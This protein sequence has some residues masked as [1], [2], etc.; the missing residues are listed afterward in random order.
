MKKSVIKNLILSYLNENEEKKVNVQFFNT[1]HVPQGF[2]DYAEKQSCKIDIEGDERIFRETFWELFSQNLVTVG[3]EKQGC[4]LPWVSITNYGS[5]TFEKGNKLPYDPD[6]FLDNFYRDLPSVDAIIKIYFEEAVSCFSHRDYLAVSVMIGGAI[7]RSVI[8][9]T[10]DFEKVIKTKKEEY[11]ESILSEY[12][13]KKKFEKFLDF[14]KSNNYHKKLNVTAREKLDSLL[15]AIVNLIR[16][17]R[18]QTGHPTGR[19]VNRDEA[20][21]N[22]LLAK[23]GIKFIYHLSDLL[24][25]IKK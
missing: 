10:E 16:I 18:N 5:K 2:I 1:T 13:I 24:K 22:I 21:A 14:L 11:K 4:K 25:K 17:T 15:P 12:K 6:G 23:E 19:L 3:S 8:V 7:E 9:M 20:E